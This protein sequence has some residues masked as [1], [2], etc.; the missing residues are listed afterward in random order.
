MFAAASSGQRVMASQK[1][2]AGFTLVELLV[3]IAIIGIL[4]ALLLP[5]VQAARE[6]ARRMAC[7][8]NLKQIGLALHNYHDTYKTFPPGGITQGACCGTPSYSTWSIMLL[9]FLEAQNLADKY[10]NNLYNEDPANQ[11]VRE[12]VVEVYNCPSDIHAGKIE[13]PE[14]GPGAALDYRHGSYRAMG[15]RSDGSGWWDNADHV[16]LNQSWKGVLHTVGT[17][18]L[19]SEFMAAI[20]DGTSNTLAV[21]EM[22]TKTHSNRGTF[23]AYTYTS[24]NSSNAVPESRTLIPDYDK[25]VAINGAGGSNTCK[26]GWGSLHPGGLQFAI[27]DGSTRFLA[28]TIDMYVWV[29]LGTIGGGESVQLPP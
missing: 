28:S 17:G 29:S 19:T 21:G 16:N 15:G 26:R 9:P 4:V 14:S 6:A 11:F 7:G 18:T 3:V 20:T 5:A 1:R 12:A 24:Y 23:W 27:C 22:T 8:N 2:N 25:C 10:N 13:K